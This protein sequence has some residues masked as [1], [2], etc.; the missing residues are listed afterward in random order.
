MDINEPSKK[1]ACQQ[2][3]YTMDSKVKSGATESRV[4]CD[5]CCLELLSKNLACHKRTIHTTSSKVISHNRHHLV[6][7]VDAS[8]GVYLV[9]QTLRGVPHPIHVQKITLPGN[10]AS[11]CEL[12][13]CLD[14][15]L[16]DLVKRHLFSESRRTACLALQSKATRANCPVA[17]SSMNSQL[18]PTGNTGRYVFYPFYVC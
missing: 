5:L 17:V 2:Y 3:I 18:T 7:G 6:V 8:R 14:D 1:H 10:S 11:M 4:K 16:D 13:T 12:S 9:S 15:S